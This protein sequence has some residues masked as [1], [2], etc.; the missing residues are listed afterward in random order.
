MEGRGGN[1]NRGLKYLNL[2]AS[3]SSGYL[4]GGGGGV[5]KGYT[6]DEKELLPAGPLR[7]PLLKSSTRRTIMQ[8]KEERLEGERS[9]TREKGT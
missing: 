2:E 4:H 3:K 1:S 5:Q 8:E 9:R 6:G 7:K